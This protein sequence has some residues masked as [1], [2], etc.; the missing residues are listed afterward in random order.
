[1]ATTPEALFVQN[2]IKKTFDKLIKEG[3][4]LYY[5]IKEAGSIRGIPDIVGCCNGHFFAWEAK[6]S[7]GEAAKTSGRIVLQKYTLTRIHQAEGI[8]MIVHPENFEESLNYLLEHTK[9]RARYVD[10]DVVV[11]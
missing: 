9:L 10:Y 1:M 3:L 7:A 6:P 2:K 5:F 8:G 4:P 11:P